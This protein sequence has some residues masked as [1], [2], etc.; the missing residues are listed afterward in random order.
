[1]DLSTLL[2]GLAPTTP[3][4]QNR[5][6]EALKF[7]YSRI[8]PIER[9]LG[10]SEFIRQAPTSLL[11]QK[12]GAVGE[13]FYFTALLACATRDRRGID[14]V[15]AA[16]LNRIVLMMNFQ[17]RFIGSRGMPEVIVLDG[18][19]QLFEL[20]MANGNAV[21]GFCIE[22]EPTVR[23][24][25]KWAECTHID[26][27]SHA[28]MWR[29]LA[30]VVPVVLSLGRTRVG[31][32]ALVLPIVEAEP[33]IETAV[34]YKDF[35]GVFQQDAFFVLSAP[36]EVALAAAATLEE[37]EPSARIVSRVYIDDSGEHRA[38]IVASGLTAIPNLTL[39][40]GIDARCEIGSAKPRAAAREP[41]YKDYAYFTSPRGER[42]EVVRIKPPVAV[43]ASAPMPEEARGRISADQLFPHVA[44]GLRGGSM[45]ASVDPF[46]VTYLH[47]DGEG[48]LLDDLGE[49]Q[50]L[51]NTPIVRNSTVDESGVRW[52]HI[53]AARRI[54]VKGP[55]IPLTFTPTLH[56]FHSH[57]L[58][59]CFP[60]VLIMRDLGVKASILVPPTLRR[61]QREMLH[62]VGIDDDEIITIPADAIVQADELIVP[63]PWP[64]V[65]SEYTLRIY[66]EMAR[67]VSGEAPVPYR[68]LLI[69]R[70]QRTSWRNMLTYDAVR[71]MLVDRYNFEVI[72]PEL[73]SLDD[74]IRTYRDAALMIGAEGAGLYSAVYGRAGQTFMAI[75][76]EDYIMPTLGSAAAV[77]GFDV[78]YAFG[79]SLRADTDVERRLPGGHSD[80]FIDP[81]IVASLVEQILAVTS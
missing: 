13:D 29:T 64:L 70:E 32:L 24:P 74:E 9:E 51:I 69:S 57:F 78:G 8:Q 81:E 75:G 19:P 39:P 61:K 62:M 73:L 79:E 63:Q 68:R 21:L 41:G 22:A 30:D 66:D 72:R 47:F 26:L 67:K 23:P 38:I 20:A 5:K 80:F 65:F 27:A 56:H 1:M 11:G 17:T 54:V 6:L 14:T 49:W 18:D 34:R 46:H 31:C 50:N 76:D 16:V 15:V 60:R 48:R 42:H 35:G 53:K 12:F 10:L 2:C 7:A 45:A 3:Y 71:Q 55:A 52:G 77:R 25:P 28:L 36:A 33:R 59:Q 44:L 58:L 40:N 4:E 43:V 37:A